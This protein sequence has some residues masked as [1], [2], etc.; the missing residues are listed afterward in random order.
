[1][2]F[3]RVL[4]VFGVCL[5]LA[6]P[7]TGWAQFNFITNADNTITITGYTGLGGSV[8]IP[9]VTNGYPVTT[10]GIGAFY[11]Q[12]NLTGV[13]IPGSVTSIADYAFYDCSS[14]TLLTIPDSVTN[15]GA[16]PFWGCSNLTSVTIP[17]S[18]IS[19]GDQPF[20]YCSGLTNI[21]VDMSNP[22]YSGAG[23]VLFNKTMATLIECPAGLGGNYTIPGSV[24]RIADWAFWDCSGLTSVT[25]TDGVTSIGDYAFGLCHS[26]TNVTIGNSVT[27]IGG[28]AFD[29]CSG[30]TS[31]AIGNS[32]TSIGSDAFSNCS[33]LTNVMIGNSV[34]SI[35]SY[36]FVGCS[37]LKNVTVG[38]SV[39]NIGLFAFS[40]LTNLHQAFFLGNAPTVNGGLGSTDISLFAGETGTVYYM[41]GTTGWGAK[42]GGWST[43]GW[44]QPQPQILGSGYGLG[45]RS[46]RFQFTIS[47]ATNTS[48]VVEGSTN[49]VNWTPVITNSIVNGINAFGDSAWTNYPQR[50]YRVR[51]P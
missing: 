34:S 17:D 8:T 22:N 23:G 49:L 1:M 19:I 51:S 47:W 31:V 4:P 7:L 35:S 14:L 28:D 37:G 43:A 10:I 6:W 45:V 44:Y 15:I 24:I 18:V 50:F 41:P 42:F 12:T 32:V 29:L 36:V 2:I 38:Y 11:Y 5:S 48:V 25:I 13:T 40:F 33:G 26:L 3:G 20:A 9:S 21:S 16:S 30:L 46:N 27:S 39:T